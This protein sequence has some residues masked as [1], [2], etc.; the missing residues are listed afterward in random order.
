M[1]KAPL[2]NRMARAVT[3]LPLDQA[4]VLLCIFSRKPRVVEGDIIDFVEWELGESGC[5]SSL[6]DRMRGLP[7]VV[8]EMEKRELLEQVA[9]AVAKLPASQAAVLLSVLRD[10]PGGLEEHLIDFVKRE[11]ADHGRDSPLLHRMERLPFIPS[12]CAVAN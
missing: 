2:V 10:D 3:R 12:D 7:F 6:L 8:R 1:P 4:V 5:N 11:L 9:Q